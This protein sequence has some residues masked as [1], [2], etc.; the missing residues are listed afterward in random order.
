MLVAGVSSVWAETSTVNAS[1]VSSS[2]ATWTGSAGVTWNVSVDGGAIDQNVTSGYAQVGTKT[3]PSK[4]ITFSTSGLNGTIT[5]IVVDCAAYSGNASLSATIDGSAFGTQNQSVPSWSN[6]SG[7]NVTFSGSASGSIVITMTNGSSGRAMYVKSITVTYTAGSS[8]TIAVTGVTLNETTL[9]MEVGEEVSLTATVAPSNATNKGVTWSSDN[10]DV[11]T[12]QNGVVTAVGAGSATI[13]VTT[14]DGEKTATCDVTVKPASEPSVT[15]DFTS[16]SWNLPADSKEAGPVS[17]TL[18]D[19]SITLKGGSGKTDGFYYDSSA[20]NLLLGKSGA[21]LTFPAFPFNVKRIKV[22]GSEGGSGSV[23]FNIFVDDDA[24][25]TSATS[26]KVT[27]TFPI[28]NDKQSAGTIYVLKV[29]NGNNTRISKIEIFGYENVEV[30]NAGYAT[31]VSDNDLDYTNVEGLEAYS[32]QVDNANSTVSFTKVGKVKAGEGVL[33]KG[34]GGSY[35]VPVTSGVAANSD[36]DF[37]RG[38]GI[39]VASEDNGKFNYILNN[40]GGVV[41][42]YAAN[43]KTVGTNRAYLQTA[44][45]N[46][47]ISL[48]FD[49][50]TTTGI[51][52][53]DNRQVTK[54]NVYNLKGQRVNNPTKGLYIVNGKKVI[55]K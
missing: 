13:T 25:S 23:T 12:V 41:A 49:D 45:A 21:T 33:L 55:I 51:S 28:I 39:A 38:E 31:Y 48:N 6:N 40:V 2:S 34:N 10:D 36:N 29:T 3:S 15:F 7:G 30:S 46:A 17:Y 24:V 16:N 50:E 5:S 11:V 4:S 27:H 8:E 32:A 44:T 43:G 1:K 42:F 22:Y 52:A 14:T 47:R 35:E 20:G 9:T 54:D 18:G 26:A 19:Y 37:I 53:I